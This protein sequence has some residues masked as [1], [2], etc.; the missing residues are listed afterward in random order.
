MPHAATDS[1]DTTNTPRRV[2]I[3]ALLAHTCPDDAYRLAEQG[4]AACGHA[5]LAAALQCHVR[6]IIHAFPGPGLWVNDARMKQSLLTLKVEHYEVGSKALDQWSVRWLQGLGSWMRPGV[7]MGARNQRTHWVASHEGL[8]YDI[9]AD[10]WLPSEVWR[11]QI[12]PDLLEVWKTDT[13]E[14]RKTFVVWANEKD[15]SPI[16]AVSASKPESNS[17]APIG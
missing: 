6:D 14:V 9:N 17:A 3:D 4:M 1:A 16:G 13:Y 10:S 5:A 11:S 8:I 15:H 2:G 12:L 7:P